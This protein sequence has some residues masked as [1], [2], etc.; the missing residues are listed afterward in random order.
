MG[1]ERKKG[2]RLSSPPRRLAPAAESWWLP[3]LSSS[4][5]RTHLYVRTRAETLSCCRV[6][7][8]L[9]RRGLFTQR[10]LGGRGRESGAGEAVA[11]LPPAAVPMS[12]CVMPAPGGSFLAPPVLG[13]ASYISP[14]TSP[15]F[16]V[17]LVSKLLSN[18]IE[19]KPF[20]LSCL[21]TL[22]SSRGP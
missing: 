5:T 1:T 14:R 21:K 11:G 20:C 13:S 19:A 22:W 2:S 10:A 9:T 6:L 18:F 16:L 8:P 15:S 12:S 4:F 17:S 7:L 3:G